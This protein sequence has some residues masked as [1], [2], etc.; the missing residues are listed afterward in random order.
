MNIVEKIDESQKTI[1]VN[2]TTKTVT[3]VQSWHE[4]QPQ[5]IDYGVMSQSE[6]LNRRQNVS[7]NAWHKMSRFTAPFLSW[8]FHFKNNN[9][10]FKSDEGLTKN[11][12][13]E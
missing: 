3:C 6:V 12:A 13:G 8:L 9:V 4:K 2:K 1:K 10:H 11:H 7:F 5:E